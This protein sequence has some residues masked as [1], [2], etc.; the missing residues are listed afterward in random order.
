MDEYNHNN[1]KLAKTLRKNITK[2]EYKLWE[3][4]RA[5]RFYG[6]KF[7]RQTPVGNYIVD[8]VCRQEKIILEIDG[9]QHNEDE[10][11]IND[12]ERT[13]Y[14]NS[15]GYK[16]YRFWNNEID[17]NIDGIYQKLKEIFGIKE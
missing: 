5:G 4:I 10:N 2:Q 8:F 3:I 12:N 11:V 16:V 13:A 15:K 6:Y 9:R 14:L 7:K 1:I 17:K